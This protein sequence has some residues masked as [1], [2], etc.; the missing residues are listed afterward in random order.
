MLLGDV[1][2]FFSWTEFE[3]ELVVMLITLLE[4]LLELPPPELVTVTDG[5]APLPFDEAAI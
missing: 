1:W 2:M 5:L 4:G 3:P